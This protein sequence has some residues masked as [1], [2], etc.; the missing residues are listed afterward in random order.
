MQSQSKQNSPGQQ[1]Y[2]Q[3]P[4]EIAL[5]TVRRGLAPREQRPDAGEKQKQQSNRNVHLIKER[6]T[7]ADARTGK[8]L[9]KYG[10]QRP[11]EHRDAGNQQNQIVEEEAGFARN[12]RV[13]LIFALEVIAIFHVGHK[14]NGKNQQQ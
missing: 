2:Y 13:K 12:H 5:Q 11:R 6:R 9:R 1:S 7:Y 4:A 8:P 14:A 10:K 3:R